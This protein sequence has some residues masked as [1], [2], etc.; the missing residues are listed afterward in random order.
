MATLDRDALIDLIGPA[1]CLAFNFLPARHDGLGSIEFR[2][3]PG[4][5]DQRTTENWLAFAL[6]FWQ[7]ASEFSG[8][9]ARSAPARAA[10]ALLLKKFDRT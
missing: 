1:R 2:R 7:L 4:V 9:G 6:A 10:N 3:A 8:Y 5:W